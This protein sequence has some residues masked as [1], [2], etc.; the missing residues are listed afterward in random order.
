[1]RYCARMETPG[2]PHISVVVPCYCS[3]EW[4]GRLTQNLIDTL[5]GEGSSFEIVLVNDGSPDAVTWPAIVAL[6]E[7]DS[8]VVG[9]DLLRN[10]GQFAALIAG[11]EEA[12]GSVV[13][14]IDDDFQ[15]P[16]REIPKLLEALRSDP[17]VDCVIGRYEA[18]RHSRFRNSGTWLMDR[19]YR[20]A[21]G[22]PAEV[23]MS[24]F[25]AMRRPVVDG[26]LTFGTVRP[27]PGALLLQTT[28]RIVN[29]PVDHER[30]VEGSSGYRPLR[31]ISSTAQ[32]ILN[33]STAPLR[34]ISLVGIGLSMVAAVALIY[35]LILA[36]M[37]R[38]PV[39]GFATLVT[40]V[41]FFGGATLFSIGLLGEYVARLV[42]EA[43]RPPRYLVRASTRD[44]NH[45]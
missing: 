12:A 16:P 42:I 40:L 31:L 24:S 35:Y 23:Q 19:F 21:Y 9:I 4:L 7:S 36:L 41:I 10:V 27:V 45:R 39:A 18:K 28:A 6:A 43:G 8:R 17:D 3:G 13:V 29:V 15:H 2:P 30:R 11:L 5:E 14:T 32:T 22:T 25:R 34:A 33:A 1:M 44:R 38:S 26:M 37:G 20:R